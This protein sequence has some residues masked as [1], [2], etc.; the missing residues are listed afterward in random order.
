MNEVQIGQTIQSPD[1]HKLLCVRAIDGSN[2]CR[3]SKLR[4]CYYLG[5]P[6]DCCPLPTYPCMASLRK[7]GENVVYISVDE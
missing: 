4:A 5:N 7:D 1:G 6:D 2:V 3:D